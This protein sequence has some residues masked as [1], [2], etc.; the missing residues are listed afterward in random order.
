MRI[1]VQKWGNS[2]AVR[3]PKSFARETAIEDGAEVD[4]ALEEGRIVLTPIPEPEFTL[5][6]LLQGVT[7][8]NRH[9]EVDSGTAQGQEIW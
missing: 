7:A 1:R 6:D 2:L 3:I 8:E 4:L 5:E 9:D